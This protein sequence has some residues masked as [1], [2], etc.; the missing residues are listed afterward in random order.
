MITTREPFLTTWRRRCLVLLALAVG[1]ARPA[2][3]DDAVPGTWEGNYICGQGE[4][5]VTLILRPGGSKGELDGLFHFHASP[6]NPGVP[7]GCFAMAGTYDG[8]SREMSLSAGRWL[9]QPFG[10]VTV[11]LA[12]RL[13]P[14]GTRIIGQ[15]VGPLCRGFELHRTSG[16][17]RT[18]PSACLGAATVAALQ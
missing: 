4:T 14:G 10:Y 5:A 11:D 15:V 16:K 17:P 12:G 13:Q 1:L 7:E 9:L 18:I 2:W 3:A 8:R 6:R